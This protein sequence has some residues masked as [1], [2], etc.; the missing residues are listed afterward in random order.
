MEITNEL[1]QDLS[2]LESACGN[3]LEK[4]DGIIFKQKEV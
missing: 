4:Y 2:T 3:F 1:K